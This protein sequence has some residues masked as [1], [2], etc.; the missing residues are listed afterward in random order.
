MARSGT[1]A[2]FQVAVVSLFIRAILI[3]YGEWQD[4]FLEVKYTDVD[5]WVYSDAAAALYAGQSPYTRHTY[6]Y[7]PLLALLLVPNSLLGGAWG[8]CLFAAFDVV[9]GYF[10]FRF[11]TRVTNPTRAAYITA[12]LWLLNVMTFTIS[13]RGNAE[14]LLCTLILA[15]LYFLTSGRH[16]LAGILYGAAIH[17]KIFPI[18]Y[19]VAIL[20]FLVG[21]KTRRSIDSSPPLSPKASNPSPVPSPSASPADSPNTKARRRRARELAS[22][23]P[24]ALATPQKATAVPVVSSRRR[25]G[26]LLVFFVASVL[27]FVVL[28]GICY[29]QYRSQYLQEALLYHLARKDHRHNFSPY[30]YLFYSEA[31]M[32]LPKNFELFVFL[33]QAIFL[34]AAG[35]KFGKRDLPFAC[36]ISTHA[37][38]TFNK[39]ITSQVPLPSS[40]LGLL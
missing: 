12:A 37:F 34:V 9:A 11:L 22:Q 27:S 6:R 13:T 15:S 14:S 20:A 29:W 5:Y 4:R 38:V 3:V 32:P 24:S 21:G 30:F 1:K 36:F 40:R 28:T 16:F 7:T 8:K 31:V 2:F 26:N 17:L 10:I 23:R 19:S 25:I 35:L 18:I 39:V 33:P